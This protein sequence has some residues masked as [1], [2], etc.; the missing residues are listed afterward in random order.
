MW[1]MRPLYIRAV[2]LVIL[3]FFE[4]SV[5]Q[6]NLQKTAKSEKTFFNLEA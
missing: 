3:R 4:F 1:T 6:E 5:V 2:T